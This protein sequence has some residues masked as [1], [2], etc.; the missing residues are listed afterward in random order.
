MTVAA[1]AKPSKVIVI[2]L[3]KTG[4]SSLKHMLMP[5]GY[6]V[7]GPRK[8]L[9]AEVRSGHLAALDD[10]MDSYDAFEDW[11]WP[12]TYRYFLERFGQRAKF[13]LTV[14]STTDKWLASI[15]AHGFRMDPMKSMRMTYGHYRPTGREQEFRSIYENHNEDV[16]RFFADYPGQLIEMCLDNGDGWQKLCQ[17]IGE[18][19]PSDPVPHRNRSSDQ[20][21]RLNVVLNSIVAHR[22][23]AS[24]MT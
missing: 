14:R 20:G 9:L 22:L 19:V 7:C 13:I 4:T 15:V 6:R 12:L 18:P 23:R 3:S 1:A 17:F 24:K 5:L 10:V 8:D 2:G 16:R 11:P 21:K